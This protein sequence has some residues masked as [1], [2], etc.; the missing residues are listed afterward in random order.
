MS[1]E[2]PDSNERMRVPTEAEQEVVDWF[3]EMGE[4]VNINN[5]ES[6][7]IAIEAIDAKSIAA[8]DGGD[9]MAG[10][11]SELGA[12]LRS[13]EGTGEKG[14]DDYRMAA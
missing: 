10:A 13:F 9:I 4:S 6:F 5:P 14:E 7:E 8:Q 12:L 1:I 3:E 11:P 2:N